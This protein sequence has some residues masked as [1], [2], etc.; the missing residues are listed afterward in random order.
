MTPT[1]SSDISLSELQNLTPSE[2]LQ[3]SSEQG[4]PLDTYENTN[5]EVKVVGV[6][7]EIGASA[8]VFG[9]FTAGGHPCINRG[10]IG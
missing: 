8:N 5:G 10:S 4:I 7:L 2:I 3:Y 1:L 9:P 6:Y